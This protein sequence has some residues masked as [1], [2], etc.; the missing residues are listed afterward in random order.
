[1][2]RLHQDDFVGHVLAQEGWEVLS[3][4]AIAETERYTGLRRSGDRDAFAAARAR[5][6]TPNAS[7]SKPPTASGGRSVSTT[8]PASISNRR[9]RWAVAWS[10]RN[11]FKR[12]REK[13]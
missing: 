1:M 11:G 4:P 12:Y 7:H 9:R 6:C 3:F 13:A 2:Q 10:R 8:L 5:L